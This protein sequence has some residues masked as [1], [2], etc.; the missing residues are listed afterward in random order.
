MKKFAEFVVRRAKL[1]I[2]VTIA[3]TIV[4]AA[5]LAINGV[6][7]NGSPET[8]ACN[9]E[10][11]AFFR[12][13]QA[14]FG[15]DRVIVVALNAD[16]IFTVEAKDRLDDLTSRLSAI[17]GVSE[18]YSLANLKDIKG[19]EDGIIIDKVIPAKASAEQ[20]Q[21]LKPSIIADPLYGRHYISTDGRTAAIS[22]FLKPM[23]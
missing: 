3:L 14:T 22:V 9:D 5:A 11:L 2:V 16:D 8:L 13:T 21:Q 20:L 18:A 1:I 12:Q 15:D 17:Q 23:T 4:F 7:F 6:K 10:A 19:D